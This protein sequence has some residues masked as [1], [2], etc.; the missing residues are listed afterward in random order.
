MAARLKLAHRQGLL[1]I[2]LPPPPPPLASMPHPLILGS[3][4]NPN[5]QASQHHPEGSTPPSFYHKEHT[6]MLPTTM[7]STLQM[8]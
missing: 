6:T 4:L 3:L 1:P 7:A 5:S 2:V 8:T